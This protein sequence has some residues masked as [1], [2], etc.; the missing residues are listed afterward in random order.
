VAYLGND[1]QVAFPTYRNID[2]ISGSFNGVTTS[3]PLTVDGVAPIPAPVNSQQCLISVNGVVQRPDDSGAEGFLLS[4]G[5]I[6]FAS[7]PAGGVDFFG[8]IL[9]G[10]DY[11][12]I[13]ANFPSGTALV[14]S[15]TFDSDL[16]TGIYNPAGN[17][18][19][20]TTAGVQR[21]VINSSGQ[22]SGG[23][24]SATTPAFSFLSDPNTGIYS[25]GAD[26]VAVATNGTRRLLIDSAG[27][28]TLDTG[29]ATIYGVRVGR[30]VG[31]ISSNT[32]VGSNALASTTSGGDNTSVGYG[33]LTNNTDGSS[34]C[35]F[36]VN[37]LNQN[38]S[39][40]KNTAYGRQSLYL[41]VSGSENTVIGSYAGYNNTG[42]NNIC[43][44]SESG[45][46]LTTGSNNTIIGS[47][48]GTAGLAN[49]VII[50]AGTTERLRID[51]SGNVGIGTSSPPAALTVVGSAGSGDAGINIASGSTTIGSKA[52]LF[53]I[54]S[55]SP[56]VTTG[57][58][59][60]SERLSPDGS[61]LQFFTVSALGNTPVRAMTIDSSQRVGIGTTSPGNPLDVSGLI[62]ANDS[63]S[64]GN[65]GLVIATDSATRGYIGTAYLLNG[66]SETDI[67]Y[68]VESGNNHIWMT[69]AAERARI[70]SSGRLL[71]GTSTARTKWF[72]ATV[73]APLIQSETTTLNVFSGVQNANDPTGP[74]IILGKSRGSSAGAVT[75]VQ[76]EDRLG[77]I[78]F[79]G[80]DGTEMVEGAKIQAYVD[81][82]PGANDLPTRLTFSTTA[83]GASSPTERLRITSSGNVGIG[84][85]PSAKLH[86]NT[87][88]DENLWVGSLGGSGAGIYLASVNDSGSANTPMQIGSASVINFAINGTEAARIDTSRRLLVGTSSSAAG[89]SRL[90]IEGTGY[91]ESSASFRRNSND[92]SAPALRLNKSRGTSTGSY[93][94]VQNG[95]VLGLV[96]FSGS[97]GTDDETGAQ[98]ACEVDGTPGAGDMPG[99]LSFATTA[100]GAS[101]PTE[102]M[103]INSAGNF[104]FFG[105]DP[106]QEVRSFASGYGMRLL[107][108]G[109]KEDAFGNG[110]YWI[111]NNTASSGTRPFYEFRVQ[112]LAKGSIT[113]DGS[114][115]AYNTTSDY[116]LKENVTT[117]T[118]G[119]TRLQQLKPSRFNFIADPDKTVD[120]FIAHEAQSVV[121]EC[122]TGAKDAVDADGNPIYQGIDQ[123][124]L[125][126]LLTAALQEAIAKIE[127]LE[128]MVAVNNITIDEQQHQ[129]STLAA[130][131]TA[132]ETP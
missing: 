60:K 37:S 29:D 89:G 5:N 98:I 132:L 32:V 76:A 44:G 114:T 87:G 48:Q 63:S 13:G 53:F 81:G 1:L 77:A 71:V 19:G 123:S 82:A 105:Q 83:D 128:G 20:F 33:S 61:D 51:S 59:I 109:Y 47:I 108:N 41:N 127:T 24:G 72:N 119:I 66:G 56:S 3:F 90:Q 75:V 122:V 55:S 117:V 64:D 7:A 101:T 106:A 11:I 94:A 35:A 88:T 18:I 130:R 99:R 118:D 111:L 23:L 116:R 40:I 120:G 8:V 74:W 12:N 52:A 95:D 39:G 4:G 31:A 16:D 112:G 79:Q 2:D 131:L 30:G 80:A 15:I 46:G 86:V 93:T 62:R 25:P 125:V 21:L 124:K 65:A 91:Y 38:G 34:N 129:L 107:N 78:S 73:N 27:A 115:I 69:G 22:V 103:R 17:Q 70:D 49:T 42:A 100:A 113:S 57:S 50:G 68:R 6:V 14:P 36:G 10:A 102:R 45:Y 121:P 85:S 96:Q 97:D 43:I 84:A 54:P 9:A 58:A 104:G 126:P 92:A 26:Q 110:G 28:L 67:G